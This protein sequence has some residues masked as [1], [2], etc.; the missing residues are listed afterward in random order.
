MKRRAFT[1]IELLVVIAIIAILAA[2]LFPVFAKAREKARSASCLSNMKQQ[3]LAAMQYAQDYDETLPLQGVPP[4]LWA[5]LAPYMQSN[6]VLACP[7]DAS[8]DPSSIGATTRQSYAF[9]RGV[10]GTNATR[11]PPEIFG[12]LSPIVCPANTI[13]II[14]WRASDNANRTFWEGDVRW[15]FAQNNFIQGCDRHLEGGIWAF[16]DGHAKWLKEEAIDANTWG[17][18]SSAGGKTAWLCYAISGS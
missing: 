2:I 6:Q 16:C 4:S 18:G 10:V 11:T 17:S 9:N 7:S 3:G 8:T 12:R 14:E 13:L 15:E 5:V 1:L